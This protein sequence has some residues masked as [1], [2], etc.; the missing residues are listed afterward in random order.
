MPSRLLR[1]TRLGAPL[2]ACVFSA[3]HADNAATATT[4][5]PS[6]VAAQPAP[7]TASAGMPTVRLLMPRRAGDPILMID[8]NGIARE[9]PKQTPPSQ[10]K[11]AAVAPKPTAETSKAATAAALAPPTVSVPV[12]AVSAPTPPPA[13]ASATPPVPARRGSDAPK[14]A[15]LGDISDDERQRLAAMPLPQ[16]PTIAAREARP[17]S[18]TATSS[19]A[20]SGAPSMIGAGIG[21]VATLAAQ[22]DRANDRIGLGEAQIAKIQAAQALAAS[23]KESAA[24]A[25]LIGLNQ[26]LDAAIDTYVV[27]RGEAM[28]QIA[29]RPEVYGNANLWPLIWDANRATLPDP[30]RLYEGQK[31]RVPRYPNASAAAQAIERAR[32]ARP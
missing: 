19:V 1:L 14:A 17:S 28:R 4:Q 11:P 8:E 32:S 20:P 15:K 5:S 29:V 21:D 23:G 10:A 2:A 27:K 7:R 12:A 6:A 16:L 9:L 26:E 25:A 18:S 3:A 22:L 31:L 24:L 13:T 30:T